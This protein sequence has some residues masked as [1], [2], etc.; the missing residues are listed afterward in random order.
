MALIE[1]QSA[2]VRGQADRLRALAQ[3]VED[4]LATLES[5]LNALMG[6]WTGEASQAYDRAQREWIVTLRKLRAVLARMAD[7]ADDLADRQDQNESAIAG[8]F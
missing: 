6:E 1:Y 8:L 2:G 3:Q 7:L 4:Q 5:R